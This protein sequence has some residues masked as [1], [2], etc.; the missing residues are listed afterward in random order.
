[1]N[2]AAIVKSAVNITVPIVSVINAVPCIAAI[3]A[4]VMYTQAIAR[5][6]KY[7]ANQ[8]W[9]TTFYYAIGIGLISSLIFFSLNDLI[10]D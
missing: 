5:G 8:I 1:M 4:G 2:T 3:G 7:K 6:D 9:K 10:I